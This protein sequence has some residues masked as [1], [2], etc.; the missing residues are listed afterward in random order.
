MVTVISLE[1]FK[2][3]IVI[4]TDSCSDLPLDY[5]EDNKIP[6]LSFIYELNNAEYEDDFWKTADYK[7]FYNVL[8][9]GGTATTSQVN[10]KRYYDEFKKYVQQGKTVIYVGFSSALSGSVDSAK[11]AREQILEE[12]NNADITVIDSKSASLGEGLL[13][14]YAYDML[15]KGHS[16]EEIISCLEENKLKVNHWFTVEDLNYLKRGG[17]ISGATAIVG[18]LLNIKP[19]LFVN[20]EGKL[21]PYEKVKGRRKA[22][23]TLVEKLKVKMVDSEEKIIAISHSDCIEDAEYVKKLILEQY[24]VKEVIVSNIGPVIGSHTGAGVVALFFIGDSRTCI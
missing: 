1:G 14:Y 3:E 7:E 21:I 6:Y 8:R 15:K 10:V 24:K 17:R 4:L 13:V 9:R 16:K 18:T 5:I 23:K 11:L 19:V 20:D 22:L 12:F 2:M